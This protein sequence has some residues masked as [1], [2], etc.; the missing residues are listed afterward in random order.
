M[1]DTLIMGAVVGLFA[2]A[3]N[4]AGAAIISH[5]LARHPHGLAFAPQP[6]SAD[7]AMSRLSADPARQPR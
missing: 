3:G 6:R 2:F 5:T 4:V 1:R 7:I